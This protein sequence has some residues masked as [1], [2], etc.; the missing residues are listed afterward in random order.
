M[1]TIKIELPEYAI[2]YLAKMCK[3]ERSRINYNV[4][5]EQFNIT[6]QDEA[7]LNSIHAI[8]SALPNL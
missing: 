3:E 2:K 6:L 4:Y 5:R 7:A 8:E 1:N